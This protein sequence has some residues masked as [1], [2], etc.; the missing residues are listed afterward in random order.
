MAINNFKPFAIGNNANVTSQADY[1]VLAALATGFQAGKASS[2]QVNK[3]IRQATFIAAAVAQFVS[4]ALAQ[5]VLDDGNSQTFVMS[6]KQAIINGSVPAGVPVPWPAAMP[7]AG[8]LKCNGSDFNTATY[9]LLAKAY[10]SGRLPDLR[11]E[12]IRGWDD[13]RGS[14]PGRVIGSAQGATCLRTAALDYPGIDSTTT[15]ATIGTAFAKADSTF[16]SQPDD[17]R[18]PDNS[19]L[20][21]ALNDNAMTATQQTATLTYGSYWLSVR[22]R[23]TAFNYIVRAI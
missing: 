4:D 17:A 11:G 1:E 19:K 3:P 23:N 18:A 5:D 10:P 12:F 15:G 7:P 22:P 16:M 2:A 13:G 6:L 21:A 8:W 9:P 14:D 20:G